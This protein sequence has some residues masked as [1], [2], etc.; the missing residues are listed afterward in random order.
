MKCIR[1]NAWTIFMI[2]TTLAHKTFMRRQP[3]KQGMNARAISFLAFDL[4]IHET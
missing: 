3:M 4:L 2:E 1:L